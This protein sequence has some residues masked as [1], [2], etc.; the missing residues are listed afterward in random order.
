[1]SLTTY[2]LIHL[3]GLAALLM[4][5]GGI[6]AITA[7]GHDL[8]A[9]GQKGQLMALHGV[10]LVLVIVAGFGQLARLGISHSGIPGWVWMK[11]VL[12]LILGLVPLWIR[13]SPKVARPLLLVLPL[14]VLAGA[15]LALYKP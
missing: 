4:S 9:S 12:W 8:K 2:N 7:A 15:Y 13:K 1:M 3:T 10:G 5:L 14:L 6:A 11:V